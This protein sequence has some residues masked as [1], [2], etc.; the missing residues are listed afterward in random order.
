MSSTSPALNNHA[1]EAERRRI[2]RTIHDSITQEIAVVIWQLRMA[3]GSA[4]QA[5][6]QIEIQRALAM[7]EAAMGHLRGL[8]RGLREQHRGDPATRA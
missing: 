4:P 6:D 5:P 1:L 3:C 7:A 8:M 2:A